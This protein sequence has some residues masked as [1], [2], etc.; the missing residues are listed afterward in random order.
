VEIIGW[1]WS[2]M[3]KEIPIVGRDVMGCLFAFADG[4]EEGNGWVGL[5]DAAR[6]AQTIESFLEE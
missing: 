3:Q 6:Y 4:N 2:D 5:G 1:D